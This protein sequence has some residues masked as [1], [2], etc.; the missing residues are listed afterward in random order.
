MVDTWEP[1]I[2]AFVCNWCTYAGADLAGTSRRIYAPN[3]RIVR[4]P[5]SG[6]IDP[7]FILRALE[8]GADGVLVS[9][10][11][12]GDCHYTKGNYYARRRYIVFNSLLDFLGIEPDRVRFAW[13]SAAEGGKWAELV[14]LTVQAVRALGP[15]KLFSQEAPSPPDLEPIEAQRP[16]PPAPDP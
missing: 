15:L 6:R 4:L 5:C 13:V 1:C 11:H 10:C 14:D 3:V 16:Q 12:P 9:G 2:V 7:R 8:M